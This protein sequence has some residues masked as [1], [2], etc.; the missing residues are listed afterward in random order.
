MSRCYCSRLLSSCSIS[1]LR[2]SGG[3]LHAPGNFQQHLIDHIVVIDMVRTSFSPFLSMWRAFQP[4]PLVFVNKKIGYVPYRALTAGGCPSRCYCDSLFI[5]LLLNTQSQKGQVAIC[6]HHAP[7]PT[8]IKK[9]HCCDWHSKELPLCFSIYVESIS[10]ISF[11][12][13]T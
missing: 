3:D 12:L 9:P 10:S 1:S 11:G 7:L 8:L 13:C 2:R 4:Y 6:K 5:L